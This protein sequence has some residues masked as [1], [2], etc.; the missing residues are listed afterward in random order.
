MRTAFDFSEKNCQV[1]K[2]PDNIISSLLDTIIFEITGRAR[3]IRTWLIRSFFEYLARI[4]SFH[5]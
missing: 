5:V 3:L 4:I 1:W 2:C